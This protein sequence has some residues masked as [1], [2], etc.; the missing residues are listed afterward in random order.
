[1]KRELRPAAAVP[2][3]HSGKEVAASP[4]AGSTPEAATASKRKKQ[5]LADSA[6]RQLSK[7]ER[8]RKTEQ[9]EAQEAEVAKR[10]QAT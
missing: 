7:A 6:P 2:S 1:M 4:S 5:A 9:L 8:R 3:Q 10:R